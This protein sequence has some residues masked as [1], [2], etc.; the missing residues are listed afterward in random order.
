MTDDSNLVRHAKRELDLL[1]MGENSDGVDKLGREGVLDLVRV[2][3]AQGHSGSSAAWMIQT[4]ERLL[5]FEPLTPLTDDPDEWMDVS[6]YAASDARWQSRRHSEAFS[7]DG[8][9]TYYRLSE[10]DAAGSL[11]VTP[12]HTSEPG[13]TREGAPR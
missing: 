11:E 1:G 5:R 7:H 10:R 9:K 2:F 3:A 4:L 12:L 8:G 13:R 6:G